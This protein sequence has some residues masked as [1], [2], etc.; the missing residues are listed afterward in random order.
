MQTYYLLP[1]IHVLQY[2]SFILSQLTNGFLI[3]QI[4]TK[5][6]KIIGS[7]KYLMLSFAICSSLYGWIDVLV[8]PLMHVKGPIYVVFMTSFLKTAPFIGKILV[9][10][11]V[12]L[13]SLSLLATQFLYRYFVL[14]RQSLLKYFE[15]LKLLLIFIPGVISTFIWFQLAFW[16][17]CCTEEKAELL[18]NDLKSFYSENSST[19]PLSG[20]MLFSKDSETGEKIWMGYDLTAAIGCGVIVVDH[21]FF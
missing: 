19:I 2:I 4:L 13:H 1:F 3:F 14:C 5:T 12:R 16:F 21:N 9:S 11:V 6:E 20:I 7:Y 10:T 8:Q 17:A 18:R 15:N